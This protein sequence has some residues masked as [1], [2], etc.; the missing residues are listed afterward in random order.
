MLT[1]EILKNAWKKVKDQREDDIMDQIPGISTITNIHVK[2]MEETKQNIIVQF[3]GLETISTDNI[4]VLPQIKR[5]IINWCKT[6]SE[7]VKTY[8]STNNVLILSLSKS[9]KLTETLNEVAI[10]IYKRDPKT[11]T[12]KKYYKCIGGKKDGR[13]VANPDDCIGVPDW[14]KKMMFSITK[15]AKYGQT[16]K[17]KTKTKLTNIVSK[18]VKKA[19]QRLKKARGF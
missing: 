12:I 2:R 19:N 9:L 8:R 16:S 10:S 7:E 3:I 6:F 4:T 13:R 11:N 5:L 17:A 18:R 1:F 15:R 14:N